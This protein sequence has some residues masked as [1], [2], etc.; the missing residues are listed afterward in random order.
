MDV[1]EVDDDE[2][3]ARVDD[4]ASSDIQMQGSPPSAPAGSEPA[5]AAD[6]GLG[7]RRADQ[8]H[9]ESGHRDEH[10]LASTAGS[11]AQ[12]ASSA[13]SGH[14]ASAQDAEMHFLEMEEELGALERALSHL[15]PI[16]L[17]SIIEVYGP[18]RIVDTGIQ[19][20]FTSGQAFD[21]QM[22]GRPRRRPALGPESG[23]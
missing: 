7:R 19:M 5:H 21:L 16:D 13:S 17:D 6:A 8:A 18:G 15:G 20:G 9:A 10:A 11:A 23:V 3:T 14:R 12:P 4:P 1:P 22:D 2:I